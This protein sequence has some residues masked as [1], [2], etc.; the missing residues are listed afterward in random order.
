MQGSAT[1]KA[2]K[3][4]RV[5]VIY[6][7]KIESVEISGDFFVHPEEGL[8]FIEQALVGI[9]VSDLNEVSSIVS[10]IINSNNIRLVGITPQNI[11]DAIKEA[12]R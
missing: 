5:S 9:N 11:E 12:I 2:E 3:L 8:A 4:V 7:D 10:S 6:R 1:K